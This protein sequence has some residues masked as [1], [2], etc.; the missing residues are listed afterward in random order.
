MPDLL[1]VDVSRWPN[2][3]VKWTASKTRPVVRRLLNKT[4]DVSRL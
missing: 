3:G 4:P 2:G 1:P